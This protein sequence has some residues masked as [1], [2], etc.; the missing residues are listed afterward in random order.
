MNELLDSSIGYN[1]GILAC[2]LCEAAHIADEIHQS[3][4]YT[5]LL[6]DSLPLAAAW[7]INYLVSP[8]NPTLAQSVQ[9]FLIATG[10]GLNLGAA[11]Q[12][13]VGGESLAKSPLVATMVV[14]A[15]GL[16][17]DVYSHMQGINKVLDPRIIF[18]SI[19]PFGQQIISGIKGAGQMVSTA[20]QGLKSLR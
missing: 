10:I 3:K 15:L 14:G 5:P 17:T 20:S 16:A 7:G 9:H 13:V 6:M 19:E 2:G 12:V 11:F 4:N 8:E 18:K 1:G